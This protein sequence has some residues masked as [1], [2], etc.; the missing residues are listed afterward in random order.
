MARLGWSVSIIISHSPSIATDRGHDTTNFTGTLVDRHPGALPSWVPEWNDGAV[1]SFIGYHSHYGASGTKSAH[2]SVSADEKILTLTGCVVDT[3]AAIS[4]PVHPVAVEQF[5]DIDQDQSFLRDCWGLLCCSGQSW[6]LDTA[7]RYPA[8]SSISALWAYMETM[9][10]ALFPENAKLR[11]L[12]DRIPHYARFLTRGLPSSEKSSD[13]PGLAQ[14]GD[15]GLFQKGAAILGVHKRFCTTSRGYYLLAP[16]VV[17]TGDVLCILYGG[18][19]PFLLR[20][21]GDVWLLVGEC[22]AC[23]LM[24][25]E[26]DDLRRRNEAIEQRFNIV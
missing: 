16:D 13:I 22:F 4:D 18:Q 19:T 10:G 25:G 2:V 20:P 17:K 15:H 5:K 3:V 9:S 26:V 7:R 6:T 24:F 21:K 11:P 23:G 1:N 14:T 8:D 12:Q